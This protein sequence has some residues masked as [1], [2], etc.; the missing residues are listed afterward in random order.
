MADPVP[1]LIDLEANLLPELI[2]HIQAYLDPLPP[3]P[4]LFELDCCVERV[5]PRTNLTRRLQRYRVD[6]LP[7]MRMYQCAADCMF[8][9][10]RGPFT[11][12]DWG[13]D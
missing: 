6:A 13:L 8:H 10:E 5:K 1:F 12:A 11:A 9:W 3:L 2:T 7:P 4:F